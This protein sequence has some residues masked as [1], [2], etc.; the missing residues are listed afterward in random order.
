MTWRRLPGDPATRCLAGACALALL[1][2]LPLGMATQGAVFRYLAVVDIT[3][4]MTVT[5]YRLGNRMVSRLDVVRQ[6]LREA[7]AGLPC[8]SQLGLGVFTERSSTLLFEPI[9]VCTGFQ[10]IA[11]ALERLDWRMAWAADSRIAAGLL[12]AFQSLA[13][14][15]ADVL[16]FTDGQEAPP[17]N[18]RYRTRFEGV[19]GRLGGW[20]V[21]VGGNTPMP[22]PKFD[23]TGRPLGFVAEDEVPQRSTFGLSDMAPE[24]IEGYH[25]RN[26]PF[27]SA[28][29]GGTEHLSA[30]RE[31][32]LRELAGA[33]GLGY[34][35]LEV[36]TL[37]ETLLQPEYARP[38]RVFVDLRW[39]P[40]TLALALTVLAYRQGRFRAAGVATRARPA[41]FWRAALPWRRGRLSAADP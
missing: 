27:G 15:Q 37:A 1:A 31:D 33:S 25:A 19:R 23:E 13:G 32:Y 24:D 17:V 9:E 41:G 7:I 2:C 39:I 28:P 5:D 22:I 26:A 29:S 12:D 14:Y 40:A 38:A 18:P 21:G 36:G 35:R 30:L 11:G 3:R 4:S 16:F 34:R 10:D 8:G 20:L 6:A